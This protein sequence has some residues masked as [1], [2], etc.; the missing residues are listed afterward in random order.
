M[1]FKNFF[2][3]FRILLMEKNRGGY[4]YVV[5]EKVKF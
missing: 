3:K 1:R 4:I 2:N 5:K